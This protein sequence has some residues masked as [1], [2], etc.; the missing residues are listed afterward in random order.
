MGKLKNIVVHCTATK[1]GVEV[2]KGWLYRVHCGPK[3]LKD[4]S[5]KWQGKIYKNRS[6]LPD[7]DF[8]GKPLRSIAGNGWSRVGY[9]ALVHLNG[10]VQFFFNNNFDGW[11]DPWE[12]TNGAKGHNLEAVHV[13]YVGGLDKNGRPKD[14][15]TLDQDL[16]LTN[17]ISVLKHGAPSAEIVGHRDLPGVKKACP[18]FDVKEAYGWIK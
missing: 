13:C 2:D 4:K 18:S 17:I 12:V 11:V 16:S 8:H 9:Y 6:E 7:I 15:R 5:V 10:E 3:D 1:E 14:T